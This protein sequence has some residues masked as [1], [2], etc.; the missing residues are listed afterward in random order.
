MGSGIRLRSDRIRNVLDRCASVIL[1]RIKPC[2]I[3]RIAIVAALKRDR[4]DY[5]EA[6]GKDS[7]LPM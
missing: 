2:A 5:S 4:F 3:M 7:M 1:G 6:T